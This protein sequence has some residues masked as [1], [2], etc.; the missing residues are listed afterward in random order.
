MSRYPASIADRITADDDV[1]G[2]QS[3]ASGILEEVDTGTDFEIYYSPVRFADRVRATIG[4]ADRR[5]KDARCPAVEDL[6]H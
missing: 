4:A 1:H 2:Q 5:L 3:A 6:T